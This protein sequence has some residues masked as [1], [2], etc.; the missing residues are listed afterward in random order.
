M[1]IK[2]II[3]FFP[4]FSRG[5]LEEIALTLCKFFL[6]KKIKIDFITFQKKQILNINNKNFKL[7]FQKSKINNCSNFYKIFAC[8]KLLSTHLKQNESKNTVILSLQNSVISIFISKIF[9]FKIYI[10][11]AAPISAFRYGNYI[12]NFFVFILK[13]IFYN[14]ADKIIVNSNHNKKTLLKFLIKKEKIIRIYN[15]IKLNS[16]KKIYKPKNNI[17]YVGRIVKEKG[18]D[19]LV[20]AFKKIETLNYKLV[21]V[22]SGS[23]EQTLKKK[24]SILKLT[25]KVLFVGW[26]KNPTKYYLISKVLV[27]P[28]YFEGFGNVLVEAIHCNLPCIA[29]KNSGG[30]DEI[31]GNGKYGMLYKSNDAEDLKRKIIASIKN[32][33]DKNK[34]VKLAK[35]SLQR[36]DYDNC[37]KEYSKIILK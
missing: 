6:N 4:I 11:S 15:P 12:K 26:K 21:L 8:A 37:L 29:T 13:I 16:I 14:F 28:S 9:N 31:L 18:L 35:K 32:S 36:F 24:I 17:L 33:K 20:N 30:P 7:I 25:K 34:L 27:L 5:G 19:I 23:Y 10:K 22:G 1:S 2:K 3:I